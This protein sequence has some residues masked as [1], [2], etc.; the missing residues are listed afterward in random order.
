MEETLRELLCQTVKR[1]LSHRRH[2]WCNGWG[3]LLENVS[4]RLLRA[5]RGNLKVKHCYCYQSQ[6]SVCPQQQVGQREW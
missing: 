2:W 5:R 3:R 6:P 1:C 4:G